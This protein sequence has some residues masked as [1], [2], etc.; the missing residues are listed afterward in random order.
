M[1]GAVYSSKEHNIEKVFWDMTLCCLA[2][3]YYVSGEPAGSSY[4]ED[5]DSK[6]LWN[7]GNYLPY[8]MVS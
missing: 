8:D 6:L 1:G 5:G 2:N 3:G 7:N 4:L